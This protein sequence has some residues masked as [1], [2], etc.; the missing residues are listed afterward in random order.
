MST[1]AS[2]SDSL[3]ILS[4]GPGGPSGNVGT[5]GGPGSSQPVIFRHIDPMVRQ[6]DHFSPLLRLIPSQRRPLTTTTSPTL[7]LLEVAEIQS[8]QFFPNGYN[9]VTS[10]CVVL[11]NVALRH[12]GVMPLIVSNGCVALSARR[13][14]ASTIIDEESNISTVVTPSG[15]WEPTHKAQLRDPLI[16]RVRPMVGQFSIRMYLFCTIRGWVQ[17]EACVGLQVNV[18]MP[19]Q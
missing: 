11:S 2:R 7:F 16:L 14:D 19:N 6:Y 9:E 15:T 17:P 4:S 13:E 5:D 3:L 12:S 18:F 10:P 1:Y 8:A